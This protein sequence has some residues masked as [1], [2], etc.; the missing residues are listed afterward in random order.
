MVDF[1]WMPKSGTMT[2]IAE[3][4]PKKMGT[5]LP[6]L[7]NVMYKFYIFAEKLKSVHYISVLHLREKNKHIWIYRFPAVQT[8]AW[9]WWRSITSNNMYIRVLDGW[10]AYSLCR[11][12]RETLLCFSSLELGWI[13]KVS[14]LFCALFLWNIYVGV[15][16]KSHKLFCALSPKIWMEMG[17]YCME[18]DALGWMNTCATYMLN[19]H[20]VLNNALKCCI[21]CSATS[22]IVYLCNSALVK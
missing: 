16:L 13:Y 12:G 8:S 18:G 1:L 22:Q 19:I 11:F 10:K 4:M 15:N 2:Q 5:Q 14:K 6:I 20:C 9:L 17:V 3:R 7:I 21:V